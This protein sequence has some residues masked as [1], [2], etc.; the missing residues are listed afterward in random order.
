MRFDTSLRVRALVSIAEEDF[1]PVT[2]TDCQPPRILPCV[3]DVRDH[4]V[5]DVRTHGVA[6]ISRIVAFLETVAL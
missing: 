5:A 3:A 4:D 1:G 6:H 2:P